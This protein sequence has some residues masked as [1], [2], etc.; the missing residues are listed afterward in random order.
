MNNGDDSLPFGGLIEQT[1]FVPPSYYKGRRLMYISR[2]LDIDNPV[3]HFNVEQ[4]MDFFLPHLKKVNPHFSRDWVQRAHLFRYPYAQ[5]VIRTH[6]SE[7]LP[8][9]RTPI[10]GVY[11]ANLSQIYPEDRGTNYAVRLGNR[12]TEMI[13]KDMARH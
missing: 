9:F 6:Y 3:Y 7:I 8:D 10:E 1:N 5:P 13:E 12:V 2:Y 4:G 11:V